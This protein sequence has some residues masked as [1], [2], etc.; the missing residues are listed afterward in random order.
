METRKHQARV[1]RLALLAAALIGALAFLSGA[2][3]A[4]SETEPASPSSAEELV[5]TASGT[6]VSASVTITPAGGFENTAEDPLP[7]VGVSTPFVCYDTGWNDLGTRWG[8][9]PYQQWVYET[10]HWCGYLNANQTTRTSGVHGGVTLCDWGDPKHVYKVAGGNGYFFTDVNSGAHFDC[11]T[12]FPFIVIHVDD[13]QVWRCNMA[14]Y[15][16][17]RAAGRS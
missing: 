3:R 4:A 7:A 9:Y 11:P 8:M 13:W 14:G 10:R 12:N 16:S 1:G 6:P 15:C 2:G 17:W 5:G